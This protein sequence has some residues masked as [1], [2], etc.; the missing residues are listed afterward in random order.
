M[1]GFQKKKKGF[2]FP[3]GQL[4]KKNSLQLFVLPGESSP[5]PSFL[6]AALLTADGWDGG[7]C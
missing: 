7:S 2:E 5:E 3:L 6:C 1:T 4:K